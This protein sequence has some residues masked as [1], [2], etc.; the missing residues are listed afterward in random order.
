MG[1]GDHLQSGGLHARQS[2]K[3]FRGAKEHGSN[4]RFSMGVHRRPWTIANSEAISA[5]LASRL[6]IGYLTEGEETDGGES[7][8]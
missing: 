5:L 2:L 4:Q 1:V 8:P 7:G 6:G 3:N